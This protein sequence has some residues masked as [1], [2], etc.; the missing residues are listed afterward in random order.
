MS[1]KRESTTAHL[2]AVLDAS[3]LCVACLGLELFKSSSL[4]AVP[5]DHSANNVCARLN[6]LFLADV[7]LSHLFEKEA[8]VKPRRLLRYVVDVV[9]GAVQWS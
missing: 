2:T 7:V 1:T 3:H 9:P 6:V 5:L 4:V 8:R